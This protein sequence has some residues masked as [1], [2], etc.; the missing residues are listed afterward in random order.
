MELAYLESD[1]SNIEW[2]HIHIFLQYLESD[3]I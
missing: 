3:I 1:I 2:N